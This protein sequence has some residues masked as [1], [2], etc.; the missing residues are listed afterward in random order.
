MS[1]TEPSSYYS[2]I[3]RNDW[4]KQQHDESQNLNEKSQT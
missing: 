1:W 2:A 4:Y 3:K